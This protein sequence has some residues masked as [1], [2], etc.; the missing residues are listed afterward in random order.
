QKSPLAREA[1]TVVDRQ[2]LRL[3][4]PNPSDRLLPTESRR[5]ERT[6]AQTPSPF[7]AVAATTRPNAGLFGHVRS[8]RDKPDT[9]CSSAPV[10]YVDR[11]GTDY[12]SKFQRWRGSK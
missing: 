7:L 10:A 3:H 12:P 1:L 2:S 11:A 8:V 5:G 4:H 6:H 9:S